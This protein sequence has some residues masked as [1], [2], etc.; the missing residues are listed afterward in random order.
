MKWHITKQEGPRSDYSVELLGYGDGISGHIYGR[1]SI[2]RYQDG[3]WWNEDG[4]ELSNEPLMWAYIDPPNAP[5]KPR[6]GAESA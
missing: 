1:Y 2:M 6:S 5:H 4:T 3:A